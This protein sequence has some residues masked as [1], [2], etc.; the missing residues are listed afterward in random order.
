MRIRLGLRAKMLAFTFGIVVLLV[1]LSLAVIHHFVARQVEAGIVEQL[2]KTRSVFESFMEARGGWL[3]TEGSV[4]AEDP[5]FIAILDIPA[6]DLGPQSRTVRQ[7]ARRFQG[8]IGSDE[9]VVTDR[10][11]RVLARVD[12]SSSSGGS[13]A[14][15]P[16]LPA[17]LEGKTSEGRWRWQGVEHQVVTGPVMAS[18][19]LAGTLTVGFFEPVEP[20]ALRDALAGAA[21]GDAL[22]RALSA[23]GSSAVAS[24]I[25]AVE[26]DL[27]ADMVAVTD[28]SGK[29]RELSVQRSPAATGS[30][31]R[32]GDAP[33][34][35]SRGP[36]AEGGDRPDGRKVL[37]A[38]RGDAGM[39]RG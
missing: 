32:R 15:L 17:A 2:S 18:G 6:A 26:R 23:A 14:D 25:R 24:A 10:A 37:R 39:A 34:A 28:A 3:R 9:F 1:A 29:P 30:S 33:T 7:E 5:R 11:G 12:V 22:P 31:S 20:S 21:S 36:E 35:G 8:L 13:L 19:R 16:T 38:R 27:G 4:V